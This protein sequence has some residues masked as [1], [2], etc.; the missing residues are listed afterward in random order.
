MVTAI[1][2]VQNATPSTITTFHDMISN[3]LPT[4]LS[5]WSFELKIFLNNKFSKPLNI[6]A[7]AVPNRYLYTLQLSYLEGN[8]MISII[9]NTKSIVTTV[10]NPTNN[11]KLM[12]HIER[13]ACCNINPNINSILSGNSLSSNNSIIGASS[14]TGMTGSNGI[15]NSGI[16]NSSNNNGNGSGSTGSSG[17]GFEQYDFFLQ[18]KLE[19]LWNLKQTIRGEGG[20]GYLL[21]V[22]NMTEGKV[23]NFKVRTNNCFLHGA[24][25][26]FLIEIEHLSDDETTATAT[27]N[28]SESDGSTTIDKNQI[29]RNFLNSIE[30]IQN[31]LKLYRFPEGSLSYNVLSDSKLDYL[32]DLCQQYCDALQF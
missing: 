19:S 29:I 5:T 16:V 22:P 32:S 4:S 9:N 30:K 15:N 25:K 3:E 14:S 17:S 2:F 12:K 31:L 23:E 18:S 1:L 26:G 8:K 27:T 7:N 24:F 13:G 21:N 6:E 11:E 10:S 20:Y 28:T